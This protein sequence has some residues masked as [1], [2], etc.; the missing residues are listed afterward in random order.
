MKTMAL[1]GNLLSIFYF[2]NFIIK[3]NMILLNN[4]NLKFYKF[5]LVSLSYFIHFK[6]R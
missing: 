1:T 6:I 3:V 2:T 4:L 5:L